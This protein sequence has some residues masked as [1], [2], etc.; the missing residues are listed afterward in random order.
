SI[1]PAAEAAMGVKAFLGSYVSTNDGGLQLGGRL[2]GAA[3]P[4]SLCVP[5]RPSPAQLGVSSCRTGDV[6]P[7]I[8]DL[9]GRG[10]IPSGPDAGTPYH[11][12]IGVG[13]GALNQ[14]LWAAYSSGALCLSVGG[15]SDGLEM[16]S[17][18]LIGA[19]IPSLGGLTYETNQPIMI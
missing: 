13:M 14:V 4:K 16:L 5:A 19:V 11:V 12:G 8:A 6:C 7:A 10:T 18:S 17:T 9:N 3:T 1:D 2:G 15:E